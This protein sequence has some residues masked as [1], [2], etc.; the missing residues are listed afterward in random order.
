M[1]DSIGRLIKRGLLFLGFAVVVY[2]LLMLVTLAFAPA[3]FKRNINF[4]MGSYGH[5]HSRMKEVK[6]KKDV[7]LL[8]LGSSHTYRGFD[9]RIFEDEGWSCFNLGSSSQSH[10]QTQVLLKRYLKRLHPKWVIYEVYPGT[11][12]TDGVESSTD[13]L[14]N[15]RVSR[16]SLALLVKTPGIKVMN[17][18]VAGLWYDWLGK[19]GTFEED[20]KKGLDIYIPG[21]YVEMALAHYQPEGDSTTRKWVLREKQLRAFRQNLNLL[22]ANGAEVLLVQAPITQGLYHSYTNNAAFDSTMQVHGRYYNFNDLMQ[23]NDSLHFFDRDHLNQLGVEAFN[24]R[25]MDL[26]PRRP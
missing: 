20:P 14:S 8:L 22:R 6:V 11:F 16:H 25:L 5:M 23:V 18:F 10:I 13:L 17:T 24:R 2:F 12:E 15:D 3:S 26:L 4:R 7:D 1:R 21:G 9:T 19:K